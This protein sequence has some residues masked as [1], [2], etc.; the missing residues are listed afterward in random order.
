MA[1]SAFAA[2]EVCGNHPAVA[3]TDVGGYVEIE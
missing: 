2:I 3:A 1:W